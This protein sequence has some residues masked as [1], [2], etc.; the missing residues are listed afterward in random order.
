MARESRRAGDR[1]CRVRRQCSRS[2]CRGKHLQV[3]AEARDA[4][5]SGTASA[6]G[7]AT[8]GTAG[9]LG[10]AT[11]GTAVMLGVSSARHRCRAWSR[12]GRGTGLRCRHSPWGTPGAHA[13]TEPR[14][15]STSSSSQLPD[16]DEFETRDWIESLDQVVDQEGE[17]RARFL[18]F[19]LLKR[20]RQRQI[21]LPALSADAVYQHD[22]PRAGADLPGR[23]DPRATD[24]A[25]DPLE[26]GG[27]GAAGQRPLPGHRRAPVH[28]RL[29]S[30]PVRGR[31]QPLLPRQ[32]SPGRRRPGLL[33]G[34]RGAGDLRSRLPRGPADRGATRPLPARDRAARA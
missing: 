29:G 7:A 2:A 13:S 6:L 21:G 16:I 24:P 25:P 1:V 20:A 26:R 14:C 27:D 8:S 4:P 18:M 19:K 9:A 32:G 3:Q 15:T 28:L 31:V 10:A 30:Q 23:R 33:P 5:A 17:N 22:Q 34:P 11:S 12:A